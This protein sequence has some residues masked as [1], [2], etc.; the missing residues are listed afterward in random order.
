MKKTIQNIP[1]NFFNRR[2]GFVRA[3]FLIFL[4]LTGNL[5]VKNN[6]IRQYS[7]YVSALKYEISNLE[8][9]TILA[10]QEHDL[11][12][13]LLII[14]EINESEKR[15][16]NLHQ[17][18]NVSP[19]IKDNQATDTFEPNANST[20]NYTN[21][22]HVSKF[23]EAYYY[24]VLSLDG[25]PVKIIENV[26][27]NKVTTQ[28][29]LQPP[30]G[31]AITTKNNTTPQ[32]I[33]T[34]SKYSIGDYSIANYSRNIQTQPTKGI[35]V[36][37]TGFWDVGLCEGTLDFN[38]IFLIKELLKR[39]GYSVSD[40]KNWDDISKE[41]L[42]K[43]QNDNSLPQGTVNFKTL[44]LL[45]FSVFIGQKKYDQL[46]YKIDTPQEEKYFISIV[47]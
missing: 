32:I 31:V 10:K 24:F 23:L 14:Q 5:V 2:N 44:D 34:F 16:Y 12:S 3:L 35:K 42:Y 19:A 43:F 15:K 25:K 29:N 46:P 11:Y 18:S 7:N 6:D 37:A 4:F 41:A 8:S 33:R 17:V 20:D 9:L 39:K 47:D 21:Q 28:N 30:G 45:G 38:T 27:F 36:D 13:K 26:C 22:E 1:N 40:S